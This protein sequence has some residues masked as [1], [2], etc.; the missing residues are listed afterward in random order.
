MKRVLVT[1]ASSGIGHAFCKQLAALGYNVTGVA[2][3]ED[4]LQALVDELPGDEHRY[5]VADLA[6]A[7]DVQSVA[8]EVSGTRYHLL[9]NNAGYSVLAPFYESEQETQQNI[10]A[11]NCAALTTLAHAF[12]R[13]SERGDA[14][15]NVASVVAYLPTPS[16]PMYSASKS[17][18]AALSECLWHEHRDRG[19]YV[20]GLCPGLTATEFVSN[21]TGGESDEQGMPAALIQ[22]ADAVVVEALAALEKRKKSIVVTGRINRLMLLLPRMLSRHRLLKVLGVVADP[23]NAL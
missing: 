5:L 1:G 14:L 19:V 11:V 10:L 20:M 22:T 9:I 4:R 8:D 2:R 18:I 6:R 15:I 23:E 13:Q 3:R 12:L 17:F 7:E 16:Q 21:A